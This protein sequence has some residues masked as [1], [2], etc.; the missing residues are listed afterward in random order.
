MPKDKLTSTLE[1][2][3]LSEPIVPGHVLALLNDFRKG[4]LVNIFQRTDVESKIHELKFN[5]GVLFFCDL[6]ETL[7]E[8]LKGRAVGI[9][10]KT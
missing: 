9:T 4:M 7:E 2:L 8:L 3:F 6:S 10:L 5:T 1:L